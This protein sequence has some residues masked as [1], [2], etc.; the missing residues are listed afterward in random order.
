MKKLVSVLFF[1]I[2]ALN[3]SASLA[4]QSKNPV[5]LSKMESSSPS[6]KELLLISKRLNEIQHT[7]LNKLNSG[8]RKNL[9]NEVLSIRKRLTNPVGG[10]IYISAGALIVIILILILIL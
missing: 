5:I 6:D 7:D 9:R 4:D 3:A 2:V 8:E 10:G 1:A